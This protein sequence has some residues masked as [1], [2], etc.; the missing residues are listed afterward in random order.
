VSANGFG[1]AAGLALAELV[2]ASGGLEQLNLS[3]NPL[4][5]APA[6][7]LGALAD[8]V[9]R[10]RSLNELEW[11]R[12]AGDLGAASMGRRARASWG[13]ALARMLRANRSLTLVD[14]AGHPI[15]SSR[16]DDDPD[17]A[18]AVHAVRVAGAL[19][20]AVQSHWALRTL[21]V[22]QMRLP[23]PCLAALV[24]PLAAHPA[25]TALDVSGNA[26][27]A[28]A[29]EALAALLSPKS[30]LTCLKAVGCGVDH[31][32]LAAIVVPLRY[33]QTLTSLDLSDNPLGGIG[34]AEHSALA[35]FQEDPALTAT[36]V[37][38]ELLEC[39]TTLTH[40]RL[41]RCGLDQAKVVQH[42]SAPEVADEAES[43]EGAPPAN[44][45]ASER[46][47]E[48]A[49]AMPDEPAPLLGVLLGDGLGS[50]FRSA[51]ELLDL[52]DNVL[53]DEGV[54]ALARGVPRASRLRS[55]M[56][57]GCATDGANAAVAAAIEQGGS[58]VLCDLLDAPATP[59][60]A[61][62]GRQ[63]ACAPS[64]GAATV[65]SIQLALCCNRWAAGMLWDGIIAHIPPEMANAAA[66][67]FRSLPGATPDSAPLLELTARL[68][69]PLTLARL[70]TRRADARL[71][72]GGF[73]QWVADFFCSAGPPAEWPDT[74]F[75]QLVRAMAQPH[76]LRA[77][78]NAQADPPAHTPPASLLEVAAAALLRERQRY[79]QPPR[80][81]PL[82]PA[83]ADTLCA[84]AMGSLAT[85]ISA[86]ET[87][88]ADALANGSAAATMADAAAAAISAMLALEGMPPDG[89]EPLHVEIPPELNMHKYEDIID[90]TY[91]LELQGMLRVE[92]PDAPHDMAHK[93]PTL[94]KLPNGGAVLTSGRCKFDDWGFYNDET[95]TQPWQEWL[96]CLR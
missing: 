51:L 93:T 10:S 17:S 60:E 57:A 33:H 96:Y 29:A 4:F 78:A 89:H 83:D 19:G 72:F 21:C 30:S 25:L 35:A 55:L 91:R 49:G 76:G 11:R 68:L 31:D 2:A 90:K 16:A 94:E 6:E 71:P 1:A 32:G 48:G 54:T 8:A 45:D 67:A 95:K 86:I 36:R 47:S 40:V 92:G 44:E 75:V 87:L 59:V 41:A 12:L 46:A 38:A 77:P 61:P 7:A 22:A 50:A 73:L 13:L 53:T 14:L 64:A 26:A 42:Y 37:L 5:E 39:N 56:L 82:P 15:A 65:G 70:S 79:Y 9:G 84:S 80:P 88:E 23:D 18:A 66:L 69:P 27:G 74:P 58:V 62:P 43:E 28:L 20:A 85:F 63:S 3:D 34:P 24:A 52:S 81:K